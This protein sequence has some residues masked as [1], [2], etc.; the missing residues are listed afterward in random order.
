MFSSIIDFEHNPNYVTLN[1]IFINLLNES[2]FS[3]LIKF[4][5]YLYSLND[6]KVFKP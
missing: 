6:F 3:F 2:S 5:S 1:Q 4:K